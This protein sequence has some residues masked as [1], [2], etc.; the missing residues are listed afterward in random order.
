MGLKERKV[1]LFK[2]LKQTTYERYRIAKISDKST[3]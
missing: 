2:G 3:K 1:H